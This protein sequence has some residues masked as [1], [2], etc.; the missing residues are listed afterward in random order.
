MSS[1]DD[2][3]HDEKYLPSTTLHHIVRDNNKTSHR[4]CG[5]P[6][7]AHPIPA[8]FTSDSHRG[9]CPMEKKTS[10]FKCSAD[11]GRSAAAPPRK[12]NVQAPTSIIVARSIAAAD[13]SKQAIDPGPAARPGF[14]SRA[15]DLT[16][17]QDREIALFSSGRIYREDTP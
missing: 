1:N 6:G 17:H 4:S 7:F 5:Q 9:V 12:V 13:A 3:F 11:T 15:R 16:I 10:P 8:A 2:T 14:V